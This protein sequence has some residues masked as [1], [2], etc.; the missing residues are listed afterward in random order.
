M[1]RHPRIHEYLGLSHS[2]KLNVEN[3]LSRLFLGFLTLLSKLVDNLHAN[4]V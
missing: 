3:L 2:L 4:P 1:C